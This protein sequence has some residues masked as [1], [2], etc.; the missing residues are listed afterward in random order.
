MLSKLLRRLILTQA[1]IG[2]LLGWLISRAW[3]DSPWQVL[4]SALGL[5]LA[6]PFLL[7]LLL[8]GSTVLR[9]RPPGGHPRPWRLLAREYAAS[10]RVFIGRQPWA[11]GTP[12]LS[13]APA[14]VPPRVPV[15]LVHGYL[16][17]H[18]VWDSVVGPLTRA[19]HTVQRVD[20]EPL[21]IPL[22][23]YAPVLQLAVDR[24]CQQ[25]GSEK[26][27]LVGHS[28]GGL[29]IRAW[30]RA[31]G[32]QRVA[33]VITLGSPHAGTLADRHPLTPNGK[34]MLWRSDWLHTLAKDEPP[35]TRRRMSLALS[36]SDNVVYP[37]LEQV[38]PGAQVMVFEDLGHLE[39][40]LDDRVIQWVLQQLDDTPN[41]A[42]AH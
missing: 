22:D 31:H 33:R 17:N 20:L 13:P 34:Q 16:C 36:P 23:Q 25:T 35:S 29:V 5:G 38:L 10:C 4:A 30:M 15:L 37:Q 28:M 1:L 18:R 6:M 39:F 2:V 27:A 19:G 11:R 9:S 3:T 41:A 8:T 32:T 24:L 42:P 40:C 14:V 26:V 21:F 12:G 7:L